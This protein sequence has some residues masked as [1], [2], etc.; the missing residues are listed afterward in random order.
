[1]DQD[2]QSIHDASPQDR[3]IGD[4]KP[5]SKVVPANKRRARVVQI[6]SVLVLAMVLLLLWYFLG[7]RSQKAAGPGR[8][9]EVVP[10]ETAQGTQQDVPIQIKRIG[11][12][13]ALSTIA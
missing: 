6:V 7:E 13:E 5:V 10:V 4:P 3:T 1:M 9:G 12:V 2:A 11:N 8:G